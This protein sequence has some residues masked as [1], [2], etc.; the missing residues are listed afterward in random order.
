VDDGPVVKAQ[1]YVSTT[2]N[3]GK[4]LPP[5]ADMGGQRVNDSGLETWRAA[6]CIPCCMVPL[7]LRRGWFFFRLQKSFMAAPSAPYCF[8]FGNPKSEPTDLRASQNAR[9]RGVACL[10]THV[11]VI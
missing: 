6:G 8:D 3:G 1:M 10:P 11:R 9:A 7:A 2:V 4:I 5:A